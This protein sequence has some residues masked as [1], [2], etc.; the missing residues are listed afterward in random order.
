M[1]TKKKAAK[2]A[3]QKPA[4]K[5]VAKKTA[6]KTVAKKTAKKPV[7]KKAAKKP[8]AGKKLTRAESTENLRQLIGRAVLD[9]KFRE[10]IARSPVKAL[11][12]YPLLPDQE[13]AVIRATRDPL[14]AANAIDRLLDDTVG[15]LGAI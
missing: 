8:V 2:K 6:K 11:A 10:L 3:A 14:A 15:P 12:E 9:R 4:K 7:A 13:R 5:T 1:A